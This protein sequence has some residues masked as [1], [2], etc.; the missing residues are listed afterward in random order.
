MSDEY[1]DL[2]ALKDRLRSD[3]SE[4]DR[5]IKEMRSLRFMEWEP[6][7]PVSMEPETVR[8]PIAHQIVE[9]MTGTLTANPPT[10]T[11]PPA[12]ETQDAR[13]RSSKMEKFLAAGM[14][15]LQQQSDQDVVDRFIESLIADGHGCM[16]MLYAPQLWRGFP[17]KTKDEEDREYNKRTEIWKKGRSLPI[18]WNWV[19]PLTVYPLYG[20]FGL[21]GV[22]EID[23]RDLLTL[24]PDKWNIQKPDLENLSRLNRRKGTSVEFAQW[25]TPETLTY[26]VEGEIVHHQK[27]KYGAPPYVYAMGLGAASTDPKYMGMS[28]IWPIRELI[29]YLDRLLSQKATAIRMWCWPTVVVRQTNLSDLIGAGEG[30]TPLREINI[31]PG[32]T[33]SLYQDEE[34]SF[35]TWQGNGPD[36]DEMVRLVMSMI[37]RAGLSDA[38]Y[39][40]SAGESGYALNQLIAAARMRF[41]PIIAHAER[42]LE[43]QME[44]LLDI[45]E[46]HAKQKLYVYPRGEKGWIGL[47]PDDIRGYRQV[48]VELN[49]VMPTDAYARSSQ[50]INEVNAGLRSRESAMEMIDIPQPDE[51][52]R[53][54][55]LDK[56]KADPKV[57]QWLIDQALKKAGIMLSQ[58]DM[59]MSQIQKAYPDMPPGLQQAVSARLQASAPPGMS[60]QQLG[61]REPPQGGFRPGESPGIE[62]AGIPMG[63]PM[64]QPMGPPVGFPSGPVAMGN[65]QELVQQYAQLVQVLAQRMGITE[66]Q[67]VQWLI[68]QAQQLGIPLQQLIQQLAERIL[69][70]ATPT[71]TGQQFRGAGPQVM[72]TPGVRA[73][74]QP[75]R[76]GRR[77]MPSGIATGMAPA[78]KRRGIES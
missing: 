64:G 71:A 60:V 20:E 2:D 51:E 50:A 48:R 13:E 25:W 8:S 76:V 34:I 54:I 27:H 35:L 61:M 1:P 46:N 67:L 65:P 62:Q 4:R 14:H 45:I 56:W 7:V 78:A 33:V 63:L 68:Q 31:A 75:A 43:M 72:A 18:A 3:W 74:P 41:K 19:D 12:D 28:C 24:H 47:G 17:R 44:V 57:Q 66:E 39:G 53:R 42:A 59:T 55:L 77:V 15:R 30:E 9:R 10:I 36:A 26:W 6:E 23:E 38:M 49:P 70:G 22:L 69:G 32:S 11:V 29:P 5:V 73:T 40:Q 21:Y 16:R 52:M 58:G 37:E